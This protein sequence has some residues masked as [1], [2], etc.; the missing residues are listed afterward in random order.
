V[1]DRVLEEIRDR[2]QKLSFCTLMGVLGEAY[3]LELRYDEVR[4]RLLSVSYVCRAMNFQRY[5]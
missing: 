3:F 1:L 2:Q 5:T 4:L